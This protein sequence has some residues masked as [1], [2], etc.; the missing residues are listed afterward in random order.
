MFFHVSLETAWS[1]PLQPSLLYF[2]IQSLVR[3]LGVS[4]AL[5][6]RYLLPRG[7]DIRRYC[8]WCHDTGAYAWSHYEKKSH[9][10]NFLLSSSWFFSILSLMP[11]ISAI[12]WSEHTHIGLD[13]DETL[14]STIEGMLEEAHARWKLLSIKTLDE[15]V[16][17]S[18]PGLDPSMTQEE[19][20]LIWE[21]YG[22]KS[23]DPSAVPLLPWA[24]KWVERLITLEKR[25]TLITARSDQKEWKVKRTKA[26]V[27]KHFPEVEEIYFVNHF[28]EKQLPKSHVCHEKHISLMIDDHMGNA[29][30]LTENGIVCI[31][32][33][34]P[35]NRHETFDHP[36]LYRV[37][38][39]QEIIDSLDHGS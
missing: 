6:H 8:R 36:L 3:F 5:R 26:W 7:V 31:L 23:M 35:W 12:R 10:I 38:D 21:S 2:C 16:C 13:L 39:W 24:R 27:E 22:Q 1:C 32:L 4:H 37:R 19:G 11:H 18:F 14:A 30:D 28:S 15:V 17:Y 25:L 34:K 33:E 20:A 9:K 29:I